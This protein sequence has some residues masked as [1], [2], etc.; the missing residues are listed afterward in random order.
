ML[1]GTNLHFPQSPK[2]HPRLRKKLTSGLRYS[3]LSRKAY[4]CFVANSVLKIRAQKASYRVRS[5]MV[6]WKNPSEK[7]HWQITDRTL[8]PE[9]QKLVLFQLW[10]FS[11][12]LLCYTKWNYFTCVL[13]VSAETSEFDV[14]VMETLV[15]SEKLLLRGL[16]K[17]PNIN[18][19]RILMV[20]GFREIVTSKFC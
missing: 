19:D 7:T 12:F 4:I 2:I 9:M 17:N 11:H 8:R 3:R 20:F 14:R 16:W 6:R 15:R 5:G 1:G 10:D 13:T 18:L